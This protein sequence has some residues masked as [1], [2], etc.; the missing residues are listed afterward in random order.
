MTLVKKHHP[1]YQLIACFGLILIFGLIMLTSAS[2]VVGLDKFADPY[3]HLKHQLLKG[4]LP[5]F[6]CLLVAAKIPYK[7][8]RRLAF[9]LFIVSIILLLLV[10]I[11]GLNFSHNGAKRWLVFGPLN[12]QPTEFVKVGAIIFFAAW[13]SL[14]KKLEE[15]K[16]FQYTL[17]PFISYLGMITALIALEP[18]IGTLSVIVLAVLAIYWVAGARFLHLALLALLG[19]VA[20]LI[21]ILAAPYR[22]ARVTSFFNPE[23]DV[24]GSSYQINQSLIAVGSGGLFGQGLGQSKQKYQYLPEVV[25]DSIFAVIAEELGYLI[26]AAFLLLYLFFITLCYQVA[27]RSP[28]FFGKFIATGIATWLAY[29]ALINVSSMVGVTPLTGLPFPFLSY[30]SSSMIATLIAVGLLINISQYTYTP[31][32]APLKSKKRTK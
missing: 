2:Q 32:L 15:I 16:S 1:N 21:L 18:D 10:F 28:D 30:G 5:G 25:G 8:W 12:F 19:I 26:T 14:K 17:L 13:F 11:P 29:Q 3:Y 7:F 22:L 6:I 23:S 9:P 20:F 4:V 31:T 27:A 24:S